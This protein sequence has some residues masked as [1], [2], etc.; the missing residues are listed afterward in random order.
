MILEKKNQSSEIPLLKMVRLIHDS[1]LLLSL[2]WFWGMLNER[3]H[4]SRNTVFHIVYSRRAYG[5]LSIVHHLNIQGQRGPYTSDGTVPFQTP[6]LLTLLFLSALR[7]WP[8]SL[9]DLTKTEFLILHL[10]RLLTWSALTLLITYSSAPSS[11]HSSVLIFSIKPFW[12]LCLK[13]LF[14]FWTPSW[15]YLLAPNHMQSCDHPCVSLS[16][17]VS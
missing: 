16:G 13:C 6:L 14:I 9:L 1:T 17:S 15:Y 3:D 12:P 11:R 2:P 8:E 7:L 10:W 5:S 4:I